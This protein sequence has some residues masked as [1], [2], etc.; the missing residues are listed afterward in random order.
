M[1]DQLESTSTRSSR[2]WWSGT[3]LTTWVPDGGLQSFADYH[4]SKYDGM[5]LLAVVNEVSEAGARAVE[6]D[7]M[8]G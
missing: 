7:E 2:A 8:V 5:G 4:N 6:A 3:K 1:C